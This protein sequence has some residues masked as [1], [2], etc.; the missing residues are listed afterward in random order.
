MIMDFNG[1]HPRI[2]PTAFIADNAVVI[3]DVEIGP[4]A[5]IWFYSIVRG[6]KHYIRIGAN[7]NIQ[8]AC[9]LHIAKGLHPLI[10]EEG[11]VLGHRVVVHGCSIGR[12]SLIGI[13][14]IVLNG[15]EIGE[16]SIIG[17]GSLVTPRTVIPPRSLAI[18]IPA[19]V[20]RALTD[21]DVRIARE[22]AEDYRGLAKVYAKGK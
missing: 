14:A 6:D 19:K 3:G 2:D 5:N 16:E 13:G 1:I 9:V 17:A 8:D 22:T 11:V 12:G 15:A 4:G 18:G 10:L 7:C 20:V 21:E